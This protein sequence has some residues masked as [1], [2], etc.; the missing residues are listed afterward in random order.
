MP[1]TSD[2]AKGRGLVVAEFINGQGIWEETTHPSGVVT[3]RLHTPSASELAKLAAVNAT[4]AATPRPDLTGYP[5]AHE[6]AVAMFQ[7]QY[8]NDPEA[9][10]QIAAIQATVLAIPD[11]ETNNPSRSLWGRIAGFFGA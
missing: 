10:A 7:D 2:N 5:P 6:L 8:L 3:R 11:A 1:N 4:E 9:A